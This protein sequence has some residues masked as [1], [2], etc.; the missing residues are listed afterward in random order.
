MPLTPYHFGP[1]GCVALPLGRYIDVPVFMLANVAVDLEPLSVMV[2]KL[3]YPLHG[4]GHTILF[5]ALVGIVL[6]GAAYL[7]KSVLESIMEV[8]HLKYK[9]C[10]KKMLA[11]GVLG[12]WLHV[13]TDSLIYTDI[14]PFFPSSANP[15]YGLL[16]SSQ[17]YLICTISFIPAAILYIIGIVSFVRSRR[18]EVT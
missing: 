11:S 15:L 4:Y 2:F 16:S 7:A 13:L 12:V 1:H 14:K 5:G 3:N 10:I 18:L 6:A 17:V 8:F 9:A